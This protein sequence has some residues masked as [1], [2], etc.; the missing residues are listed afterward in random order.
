MQEIYEFLEVDT[1]TLISEYLTFHEN[2]AISPKLKIRKSLLPFYKKIQQ[3]ASIDFKKGQVID[4]TEEQ[5][6]DLES[7]GYK[8][9]YKK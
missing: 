5:V 7:K 3:D 9:K 8:L 2:V 1:W 4:L 6:K